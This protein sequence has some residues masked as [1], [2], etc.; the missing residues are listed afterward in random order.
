MSELIEMLIYVGP[1]KHI[2]WGQGQTNPVA[3]QGAM[4]PLVESL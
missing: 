2:R 3:M 1:R 4:W